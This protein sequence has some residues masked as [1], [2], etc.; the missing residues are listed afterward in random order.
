MPN[1]NR[2]VVVRP[3]GGNR[4]NLQS[5]AAQVGK[6]ALIALIKSNGPTNVAYEIAR[7]GINLSKA[8]AQWWTQRAA[9]APQEI[10]TTEAPAAMGAVVRGSPKFN[11]NIRIRHRELIAANA[12]NQAWRINP[13]D[14]STFPYLSTLATMFDKYRMHSLRFVVVSANAT[15]QAG[16]WYCAFDPDSQDT[17][18]SAQADFMAMQNS[19]SMTAW[20]SGALDVRMDKNVRFCSYTTDNLK[21]IGR[22][23]LAFIG[24]LDLYVEYDVELMDP[25]NSSAS[26]EFAGTTGSGSILG[27][28]GTRIG[29]DFSSALGGGAYTL[30]N[31]FYHC[32]F[33]VKGTGCSSANSTI[34]NGSLVTRHS[35]STTE[36][37]QYSIID[38]TATGDSILTLASTATTVVGSSMVI[39]RISR[40]QFNS[41]SSNMP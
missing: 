21:D 27:N 36:M 18:P 29:A 15:A 20:Q 17:P 37:W 9:S 30:S 19:M 5:V 24:S 13:V 1:N 6:D 38:A 40:S 31:G 11:G 10:V 28:P 23:T 26:V 33:Y 34:V 35:G 25:Q 14:G 32:A 22:F 16:R 7:G 12:G 2:Q 3:K 39:T 41:I 8:A 4:N